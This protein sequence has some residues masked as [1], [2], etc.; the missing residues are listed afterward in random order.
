M[1]LYR[2]IIDKLRNNKALSIVLIFTTCFYIDKIMLGPFTL[3]R[4]HDVFNTDYVRYKV[5]GEL[6]LKYGFFEWY[7]HYVGG[8]PA[9][10]WH[11]TPFYILNIISTVLPLWLVYSLMCFALMALAGYGMFRLMKE[12]FALQNG[13]AISGGIFFSL[14]TQIQHNA[15]P[16]TIFNYVFP[17]YFVWFMDAIR[18]E[19]KINFVAII[20]INL[21]F[22]IA[23]PVLTL[24]YFTI[25][26]LGL[27]LI[28]SRSQALEIDTKNI[29]IKSCI[30]WV[31]YIFMCMPILY[32]LW[33]YIP[34]VARKFSI[35]DNFSFLFFIDFIR[36]GYAC[37]LDTSVRT[38]TFIPLCAGFALIRHSKKVRNIYYI[39]FFL[40]LFAAFFGS[41]LSNILG[42]TIFSKMDL[43]H[44]SWTL[45]FCSVLIVFVAINELLEKRKLLRWYLIFSFIAVVVL[46][47]I[48]MKYNFNFNLIVSNYYAFSLLY[49]F[50]MESFFERQI[51]RFLDK[52]EL[53]KKRQLVA[54]AIL[55]HIVILV[56]FFKLSSNPI[57]N[58]LLVFNML[59]VI[60]VLAFY[61]KYIFKPP[62]LCRKLGISEKSFF[63]FIVFA[64]IIIFLFCQIRILRFNGSEPEK[65]SFN[66]S[67]KEFS[68]L[69]TLK[70]NNQFEPYRAG[71]LGQIRP[72]SLN[73]Y[74]FETIDGRGA[75]MPRQLKDVFKLIIKKQLADRK[76]EEHF[77]WYWYDLLL[78][79]RSGKNELNLPL[80]S[81]ANVKYLM[82]DAYNQDVEK[83]SKSVIKSKGDFSGLP[84][85]IYELKDVFKRGFLAK[86][87]EAIGN[88]P[89]ML[90]E[91]STQS[92]D[93]LRENALFYKNEIKGIVF[94]SK[95]ISENLFKQNN[96]KLISYTPDKLVFDVSLI[97]PAIVVVSNNYYPKWHA[98]VN[99][100]E[101]KIF[102]AYHAFQAVFIKNA[103]HYRVVFEFKD[104][105]LWICHIVMIIGFLL[106]NLALL[107]NR[108]CCKR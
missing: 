51:N 29:F 31:G 35:T 5:M 53:V 49:L 67:L 96:I 82:S 62:I 80:L 79:S 25:L 21:I 48:K 33:D 45:P 38:L 94:D 26:N 71:A 73:N 44:M 14:I 32:S 3:V 102:R 15:I 81:L 63:K 108:F 28:V 13:L 103:G 98:T 52:V 23:Y 92:V 50:L 46:L 87:V 10:A 4:I 69:N 95:H 105:F 60:I 19:K 47:I 70:S 20:G 84:L 41:K 37:F 65:N 30:V 55:L 57:S 58:T 7:P 77:D 78:N 6:L 107:S 17:I 24:P 59:L 91:L 76:D 16:L 90:Y 27:I 43:S 72:F 40:L 106:I 9:Y 11:H 85:Y 39:Y 75:I 56:L 12:Y 74:G 66:L 22:L 54:G 86:N 93:A 18:I 99:G 100:L 83:F 97:T 42:N 104:K 2:K 36:K 1:N 89:D 88:V 101:T 61:V 34:F 8:V 64:G 68:I